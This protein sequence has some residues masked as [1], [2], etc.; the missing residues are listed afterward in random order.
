M[1]VLI[2]E[3]NKMLRMQIIARIKAIFKL[4]D[5]DLTI[6]EAESGLRA[7]EQVKQMTHFRH[8]V[9]DL[10]Y[11]DYNLGIGCMNGT[12]TTARIRE[13]EEDNA[14][15]NSIIFTCSSESTQ[16]PLTDFALPKP[17]SKEA[18]TGMIETLLTNRTLLR[19]EHRFASHIPAGKHFPR[20]QSTRR[21]PIFLEKGCGVSPFTPSK[22]RTPTPPTSPQSP[23]FRPNAC[24]SEVRHSPTQSPFLLHPQAQRP[25]P[26]VNEI[27]QDMQKLDISSNV[28]GLKKADSP[29]DQ[30]QAA[31]EEKAL[32]M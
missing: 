31:Q 3:D 2:V 13:I 9:Y 5:V 12:E 16:I 30:G 21:S 27:G 17:P 18:L 15:G 23:S 14:L 32:K 7:I 20:Y 8:C 1:N 10:V 11:M 25:L 28:V 26:P 24:F 29:S 19:E 6:H 4:H 22:A